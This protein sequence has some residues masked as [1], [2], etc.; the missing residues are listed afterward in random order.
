MHLRVKIIAEIGVNHNGSRDM[1]VQLIKSAKQCGADAVKIQIFNTE[2][3]VTRSAD[4]AAYQ[5]QS[6][7]DC[8]TQFDMLKQYELE[9]EEIAYV[10]NFC[11][12]KNIE[13]IATPFDFT[14][15]EIMKKLSFDT[16]KISSGDITNIPLLKKVNETGKNVI[17]SAGMANLAEIEEALAVFD[18]NKANLALLH[19][20]SNYPVKMENVNLKAI[21]T[22]KCAFKKP[23]GYSDHTAGM[24]IP[25]A[26]AALGAEIIEKH[27][28]LDRQQSG[29]DHRASLEPQMFAEMVKSIRHLEVALGDGIKKCQDSEAEIKDVARKSIVAKRDVK[30]GELFTEDNVAVKRP[31]TGLH[32]RYY[33][34]I[35]GKK[36]VVDIKRDQ[37][38]KLTMVEGGGY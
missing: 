15:L 11:D 7:P 24:E 5:K 26:A 28:T 25:I 13:L 3:M 27:F 9:L 38:I 16:V 2:E 23:V 6:V 8:K 1:A 10:K 31:G 30:A 35:I 36:T 34:V 29:P 12:E 33:D 32:P 18:K 20:T 17:I 22:L 37:Q 4:K 19:C 14:S 21:E